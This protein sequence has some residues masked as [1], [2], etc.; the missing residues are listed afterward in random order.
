MTILILALNALPTS[1]SSRARGLRSDC[2]R[3]IRRGLAL[4][5]K[6]V[7]FVKQQIMRQIKERG[8]SEVS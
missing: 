1:R 2:S 5:A 7:D 4:H 6:G 8:Q 3:Y